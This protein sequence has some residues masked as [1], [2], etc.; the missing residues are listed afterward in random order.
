MTAKIAMTWVA[1]LHSA[2][3]KCDIRFE[4]EATAEI[5]FDNS[6]H[7][8]IP[9]DNCLSE[10]HGVWTKNRSVKRSGLA[11]NGKFLCMKCHTLKQYPNAH[12]VP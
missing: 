6:D 2:N 11:N 12:S 1:V 10:L 4:D 3:K 8:L 9:F 5:F 7:N